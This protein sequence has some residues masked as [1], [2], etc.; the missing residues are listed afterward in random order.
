MRAV[1]QAGFRAV[2][3]GYGAKLCSRRGEPL[4]RLHRGRSSR[5]A[6]RSTSVPVLVGHDWGAD[7]VQK[8]MVMRPD[9]F[10]AVVSE[11]SLCA[12]W[13]DQ[14]LERLRRRDWAIHY[15]FGA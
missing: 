11:H 13:R 14:H 9:R 8:A 15:A 10:R 7:V 2:A 1:A 3:L 6:R 4:R 5:R 12:S